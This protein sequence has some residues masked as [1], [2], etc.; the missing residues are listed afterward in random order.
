MKKQ[1]KKLVAT[2]AVIAAAVA[3][4]T[5]INQPAAQAAIA[6]PTQASKAAITTTVQRAQNQVGQ[7]QTEV[8]KADQTV[9]GAQNT[10]VQ[11]QRDVV[12]VQT[13]VDEQ[14]ETVVKAQAEVTKQTTALSQAQALPSE[15]VR[16]KVQDVT[17]QIKAQQHVVASAEQTVNRAQAANSQAQAALVRSNAAINQ[18]ELAA[19][20][21]TVALQRAQAEVARLQADPAIKSYQTIVDTKAQ[22]ENLRQAVA[23]K[24]DQVKVDTDAVKKA[25]AAVSQAEADYTAASGAAQVALISYAVSSD[26]V[27][28]TQKALTSAQAVASQANVE[29]AS[30]QSAYQ[31]AADVLAGRNRAQ[32]EANLQVAQAAYDAASQVVEKFNQQLAEK[33]QTYEQAKSEYRKLAAVYYHDSNSYSAGAVISADYGTSASGG[34]GAPATDDSIDQSSVW[35]DKPDAPASSNANDFYPNADYWDDYYSLPSLPSL[36]P[37]ISPG[38]TVDPDDDYW[39]PGSSTGNTELDQAHESLDQ[40]KSE[41]ERLEGAIRA[42]KQ[43]LAK[44]K[45]SG[46]TGGNV[47]YIPNRYLSNL[48]D[49]RDSTIKTYDSITGSQNPGSSLGYYPESKASVYQHS[50]ADQQKQLNWRNLDNATL[51]ELAKYTAGLINGIR[52]QVGTQPVTVTPDSVNEVLQYIANGYNGAAWDVYGAH[53][54]KEVFNDDYRTKTAAQLGTQITESGTSGLASWTYQGKQLVKKQIADEQTLDSLKELIYNDLHYFVFNDL[55]DGCYNARNIAGLE[56]ESQHFGVDVDEN[57]YTHYVF[58]TDSTA[59]KGDDY[60]LAAPVSDTKL[61]AL[62]ADLTAANLKKEQSAQNLRAVKKKVALDLQSRQAVLD[63]MRDLHD[64]IEKLREEASDDEQQQLVY[65]SLARSRET[66]EQAQRFLENYQADEATKRAAVTQTQERLSWAQNDAQQAV[67]KLQTHQAELQKSMAIHEVNRKQ[68]LAGQAKLEVA[69]A[70]RQAKEKALTLVK[71]SLSGHQTE[72]ANLKVQL[73]QVIAG[74]TMTSSVAP[75]LINELDAAQKQVADL[76][77]ILETT[78][79]QLTAQQAGQLAARQAAGQQE[80]EL[81][82]SSRQL[83]EATKRLRELEG[84]LAKLHSGVSLAELVQGKLTAAKETLNQAIQ[85]LGGLQN[86]LKEAQKNVTWAQGQLNQ[87]QA[88]QR[89]AQA[90]LKSALAD[91]QFTI[92]QETALEAV[93]KMGSRSS[94]IQRLA[95]STVPAELSTAANHANSRLPQTG[96]VQNELNWAAAAS[97][98]AATLLTGTVRT[99]RRRS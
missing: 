39:Y 91:Q 85:H 83:N 56:N 55:K 29:L 17:T 50:Q 53:F 76:T 71:N 4:E 97:L 44:E 25:E 88:A 79:A 28:V 2:T 75:A 20:S 99:K 82:Q 32:A 77:E 11:A 30:A 68:A 27:A 92:A 43:A 72:L 86:Q 48:K 60:Q 54:D 34:T 90:K 1:T 51:T 38:A 40:A 23:A 64:L 37:E 45:Y 70:T 8:K 46:V 73:D 26:E 33:R 61:K 89:Q 98:A 66:L 84:D 15:A 13:A 69:A 18:T 81:T 3:T 59:D 16:R 95:S 6:K 57:G 9:A 5:A 10:L 67:A 7:A 12:K 35:T 31:R 24:E 80:Q 87:A 49:Y 21:Q 14:K 47:I 65:D 63:K 58:L 62:Q 94:R 22:V 93:E 41:V 78:K 42:E 52:E 74:A 19:S 96:A 36:P